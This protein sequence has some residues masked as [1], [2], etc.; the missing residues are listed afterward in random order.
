MS[1][2]GRNDPCPCG[3]GK[4]YKKCCGASGND[5]PIPAPRAPARPG[6]PGR[7]TGTDKHGLSPDP[8]A[9]P[10]SGALAPIRRAS[11]AGGVPAST[12]SPAI[13]LPSPYAQPERA[14]FINSIGGLGD[15]VLIPLLMQHYKK[16]FPADTTILFDSLFFHHYYEQPDYIDEIHH[17]GE[18]IYANYAPQMILNMDPSLPKEGGILLRQTCFTR[19]VSTHHAHDRKF[20]PESMVIKMDFVAGLKGVLQEGFESFDVRLKAEHAAQVDQT[21]N[22]LNP[23]G[24]MLIG[25][26]TRKSPY[27]FMMA[28]PL[29]E[30]A[31]ELTQIAEA[32]TA[33]YSAR[34]L[35]CGDFKL[36]L[37]RR[38]ASS[39]WIDLDAAVPNIYYK[40]EIMKRIGLYLAAPSGFSIIVNYMRG[41]PH[42]PAVLLYAHP[43][44]FSRELFAKQ[45]PGYFD[46][47][48]DFG[49][50]LIEWTFRRP[51]LADFIF[52]FP[53][54]PEKALRYLERMVRERA[55]A[56]A[57]A[58]TEAGHSR[59]E[60]QEAAAFH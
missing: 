45:Y 16:H 43:N 29:E 1:K 55:G 38:Y 13:I 36:P 14:V 40:F 21:M 20:D 12:P 35:T 5:T 51:D 25:I 32:L 53:H 37:D 7:W 41:K 24:R 26:Q 50:A 23:D 44:M 58:T 9:R 15:S 31:A 4:K 8:P 10:G 46:K 54:T 30:Y 42:L 56:S 28:K 59:R 22:R 18:L 2:T 34:I 6:S 39:D 11:A 19:F 49:N 52:D 17:A 27:E 60:G 57:A 48:G 47:G 33:G 3:S